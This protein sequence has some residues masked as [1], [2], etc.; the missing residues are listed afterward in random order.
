MSRAWWLGLLVASAALAADEPAV[1]Q[2]AGLPQGEWAEVQRWSAAAS[3][4]HQSGHRVADPTA[5]GG[6]AWASVV[7]TDP[8]EKAMLYGPYVDQPAGLYVAAFRLKLLAAIDD[9]TVLKLDACTNQGQDILAV[10]DLR[11]AELRPGEWVEQPLVFRHTGG[12]LEA[13]VF[14][15]GQADIGVDRVVLYRVTGAGPLAGLGRVPQPSYS[16]VPKDLPFT[17]RGVTPAQLFPR[18][19]TPAAKMT[20]LD[21]RKVPNDQR[22]MLLS[23]QG[24]VNRVQ[25]RL[26][27][28]CQPTDQ[29]WLDCLVRRGTV[30]TTEVVANPDELLTRWADVVKGA[31]VWDP[32]LPATKNLATMLAGVRD[33]LV[34][35]PRL[36]KK[37]PQLPVLED[38]RGRFKVTTEVYRWAW[39]NLWPRMNHDVIACLWP[40]QAGGLRDYLVQHRIFTFWLSGQIDGARP[41]ADAPGEVRL[42]EELLAKMPVNMPVLGYPWA[43]KDVGIGEGP[44]VTLFAQFGKYLVGSVDVTNLSVHTGIPPVK[45]TQPVVAPPALDDSKIYVQWLMSDGDNLPVLSLHNFPQLWDDPA[46]GQ[47]PIAWTVSPSA[48]LLIPAIVEDYYRR[49]TP[50]DAFIGA[51]SGIGYTYPDNYGTR[52]TEPA[53]VFDE[54]L[55]QTAAGSLNLDLKQHWMMGLADPTL[56][57]RYARRIPEAN[58]LFPDYGRVVTGYQDAFYP[59]ERGVPV[60]RAALNWDER[61]NQA[62]QIENWLDQIKAFVPTQRPAFLQLFV[63]NWGA[64][65]PMLVETQRRLGPDYVPLRPDQT[66]ALARQQLD[67]E[68]V[69]IRTATR[70]L[71]IAGRP[72]AVSAQV[73]NVSRTPQ[74]IT[75]TTPGGTVQP[76]TANLAPS[77][78]VPATL[79]APATGDSV[80][81]VIGGAFGERRRSVKLDVLDSREVLGAL[82]DGA[83][84]YVDRFDAVGLAHRGGAAAAV[85]GSLAPRAWTAT[86]GGTEPGH[87]VFGP[88]TPLP[89]GRYVAL[90]RLRRTG[91]GTGRLLRLDGHVGG[92]PTDLAGRDLACGDLPLGAWQAVPLVLD[93]P[94]GTLETRVL[95]SGAASVA[96]DTVA[97]WRVP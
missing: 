37:Y 51:V 13:R 10:R 54:F 85:A 27:C 56:I 33:G 14:W 83:W 81:W 88:Y 31:I 78:T 50:A 75:L 86:A 25:P 72:L 41:G 30:T 53:K 70:I 40:D 49:A 63:W 42:M 18:S 91:D 38:L 84:S 35:S 92:A 17:P 7:G 48:A 3:R 64:S 82:P 69:Q 2:L 55:D 6:F 39:D 23:F 21:L 62:Q 19:A 93:H 52:F 9:D 59:T 97:L 90:F 71:A 61:L 67:R 44:G 58:A 36:A 95:W 28:L 57:G 16:G 5:T 89:A 32:V 45:L 8:A 76:A 79:Q 74:T 80:T 29:R 34:L 87:I 66:A 73:Q 96:I 43:G 77:A 1:K 46:R 20:V 26:Y 47:L 4:D 94:G 22:L 68:Q 24:L 12:K 65:L 15:P 60:V 11:A